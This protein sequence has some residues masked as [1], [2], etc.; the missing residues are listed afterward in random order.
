MEPKKVKSVDFEIIKN[1]PEGAIHDMQK[2]FSFFEW[3]SFFRKF[4][5]TKNAS[6]LNALEQFKTVRKLMNGLYDKYIHVQYDPAPTAL[7]Q[8]FE[9][10][11]K[12]FDKLLRELS[13]SRGFPKEASARLSILMSRLRLSIALSESLRGNMD[14]RRR[15]IRVK[16]LVEELKAYL[17]S[18]VQEKPKIIAQ[19]KGKEFSVSFNLQGDPVVLANKLHLRRALFNIVHDAVRHSFGESVIVDVRVNGGN[20]IFRSVNKGRQV[21]KQVIRLIGNKPYTTEPNREAPHGYGKIA[22]NEIIRAHGG[23]FRPANLKSGF[24][25]TATLPHARQ[26]RAA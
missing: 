15:W 20:L 21:P 7:L 16:P 10:E 18:G 12:K 4:E 24:A 6:Y 25:L 26:R 17:N 8:K 11:G 5:D 1:Y 13:F 22:A 9:S 14:F 23:K 3:D 19:R 2:Y